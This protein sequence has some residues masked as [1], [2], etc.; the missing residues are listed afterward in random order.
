M[1]TRFVVINA[2]GPS[3]D[4]TKLRRAQTQWDEHAVFMDR[5]AADGFVVLGGP[6][7]EG[8]GDD[9]LLVIEAAAEERIIS[10]LNDDP[11]IK[12]GIIERRSIQR[13]TILLRSANPC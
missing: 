2:K 3:W 9:N 8:D 5:L 10:T 13:W 11:W 4:P 1:N 12:S 6:L 7:G